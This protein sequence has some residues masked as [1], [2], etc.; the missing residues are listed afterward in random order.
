LLSFLKLVAI[1]T[2]ADVV[3]LS[4]ENR[5][6]V[7]HGLE[8]L[9]MVKNLGLRELLKVAGLSEG[10]APSARVTRVERRGFRSQRSAKRRSRG[11][12]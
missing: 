6:I 12:A 3:P 5:I 8:G 11:R 7:K 4:G 10:C 9:S 1:G 2:V